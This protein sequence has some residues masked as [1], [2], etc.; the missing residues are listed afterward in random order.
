MIEHYKFVNTPLPYSYDAL[1][2]YIDEK[3]M[4]LHHDKHLQTY[5][6]HL[7]AALEPYP[8]F[9]TW[10]LEQLIYN[11]PSLPLELQTPV[12]NNGGGVYNHQFYFSNLLNPAPKQPTGILKEA[13]DQEFGSYPA[14]VEQFKT[15]GSTLFGS[16]YVWLVLDAA[17][18]LRIIT[19]PNQDTPLTL[20]MFPLLNLDVWEHAYYLKHYNLRMDY[21]NDWFQIIDWDHVNSIYWNYM[22]IT[23]LNIRI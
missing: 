4:H 7:N 20:G 6:D 16:G 1:E 14:F 18:Q 5:I 23:S 22:R 9:Q 3:T 11:V 8:Q 15:A 17:R 2:P 13:I 19:T 21:I 10:S 12:R